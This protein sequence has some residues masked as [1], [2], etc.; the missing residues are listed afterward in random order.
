MCV[1]MMH[2]QRQISTNIPITILRGFVSKCVITDRT[3]K[4]AGFY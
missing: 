3:L 4:P 1:H 2:D